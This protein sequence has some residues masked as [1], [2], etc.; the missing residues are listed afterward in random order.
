MPAFGNFCSLRLMKSRNSQACSPSR[1][2]MRGPTPAKLVA[3]WRFAPAC[4]AAQPVNRARRRNAVLG[5]TSSPFLLAVEALRLR[6]DRAWQQ[7][8]IQPTR[9]NQRTA[10]LRT[11][12]KTTCSSPALRLQCFMHAKHVLSLSSVLANLSLNR[13]NCGGPAFGLQEPSPN[14][15][16]PQ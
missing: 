16:P 14:T 10:P 1:S 13:T 3:G 12:K 5:S 9:P 6:D 11:P 8:S 15:S 7:M 4:C 2:S